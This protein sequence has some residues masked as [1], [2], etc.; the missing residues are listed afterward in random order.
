[1]SR[2]GKPGSQKSNKVMMERCLKNL[3]VN[4]S[5]PRF[6]SN[7]RKNSATGKEILGIASHVGHPHADGSQRAKFRLR[8]RTPLCR[9]VVEK[10]MVLLCVVFQPE[11]VGFRSFESPKPPV[12]CSL[13]IGSRPLKCNNGILRPRLVPMVATL[14]MR[15][16][17]RAGWVSSCL[18]TAAMENRDRYRIAG[19]PQVFWRHPSL[20]YPPRQRGERKRIKHPG[21]A[22]IPLYV[23]R[24]LWLTVK[25]RV[26]RGSIR[27]S[28]IIV[29][30]SFDCR[31]PVQDHFLP[32]SSYPE[33]SF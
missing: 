21:L 3:A 19:L 31:S 28:T 18:V 22:V 10:T 8:R 2:E 6:R 17:P 23:P 27:E 12:T 9:P 13:P 11:A 4:L 26:G 5:T 1:M 15:W 20:H 25:S 29:G 32:V 30:S 14:T 16:V 24:N 7:T 33:V